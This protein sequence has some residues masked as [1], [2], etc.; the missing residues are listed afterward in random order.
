MALLTN[1]LF[2]H[3]YRVISLLLFINVLYPPLEEYS[4]PICIQFVMSGNTELQDLMNSSTQEI[5][6][7]LDLHIRDQWMISG[8]S[9]K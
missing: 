9:Q 3:T 8:S 2:G 7:L 4:E 5:P 6:P 1:Q